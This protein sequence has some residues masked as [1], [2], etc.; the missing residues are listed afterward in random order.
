MTIIP[1][2]DVCGEGGKEKWKNKS[3]YVGKKNDEIMSR[4]SFEALLKWK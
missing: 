4:L 2:E 3:T 1:S